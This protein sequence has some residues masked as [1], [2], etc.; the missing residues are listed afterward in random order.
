M[1]SLYPKQQVVFNDTKEA[2]EFYERVLVQAPTGFGKAVIIAVMAH[3]AVRNDHQVIIMAHRIELLEQLS[4]QLTR[5]GVSHGWIHGDRFYDPELRVHLTTP[6]SLLARK[7]K[8]KKPTFMKVDE[9]HHSPAKTYEDI[10]QWAGPDCLIA[11]FTATPQR[12]DGKPLADRFQYMVR[13]PKIT[14]LIKDKYLVPARVYAPPFPVDKSDLKMGKS[15]WTQKSAEKV[16]NQKKVIGDLIDHYERL[17]PGTSAVV[18][19]NSV[20]HAIITAAEFETRG[21]PAAALYCDMEREKR[22]RIVDAYRR[23]EILILTNY[24][25]VSE[26]FDLPKIQTCIMAR[27]TE[28]LALYLQMVGRAI[29]SDKENGKT[30]AIVLDHVGNC[31]RHGMPDQDRYWSLHHGHAQ[32]EESTAGHK[33]CPEC[34]VFLPKGAKYCHCGYDFSKPGGGKPRT[35]S[36]DKRGRLEL[37][38]EEVRTEVSRMAAFKTEWSKVKN[39]NDFALF[40]EIAKKH[41][42]STIAAQTRWRAMQ[43]K[44]G[45]YVKKNS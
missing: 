8:V 6:Q 27:F 18:F 44:R 43:K 45:Q 5:A 2:F 17:A 16:L 12:L 1:I 21:W 37:V 33:Q 32:T 19:C 31:F 35:F 36:T 26:G 14:D 24:E 23:G 34:W 11:G 13:G 3:G 38:P 20:D 9:C 40:L 22:V 30:H 7:D 29:R 10:W 41:G 25:L 4:A 28:S 15:D 42:Y 39:K